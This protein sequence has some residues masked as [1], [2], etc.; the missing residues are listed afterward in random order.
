M[1]R[2]VMF[3]MDMA[4]WWVTEILNLRKKKQCRGGPSKTAGVQLAA[5]NC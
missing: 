4:M 2:F 3:F 1:K 5:L